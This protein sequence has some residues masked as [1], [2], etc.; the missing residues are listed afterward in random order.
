MIFWK[1]SPANG[2]ILQLSITQGQAHSHNGHEKCNMKF[3][4]IKDLV[5]KNEKPYCETCDKKFSFA[6]NY[7]RHVK[8]LHPDMWTCG[9]NHENVQNTNDSSIQGV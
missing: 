9:E 5:K 4:E 3:E 6:T 1:F 7:I 2:L 8:K